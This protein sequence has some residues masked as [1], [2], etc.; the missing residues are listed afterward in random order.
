MTFG[1]S[2]VI[3][4]GHNDRVGWAATSAAGAVVSGVRYRLNL[5]PGS[6]TS[7]LVD[8]VRYEMVPRTVTVQIRNAAGVIEPYAHTFYDTM[9]GMVSASTTRPWTLQN[10]YT[11]KHSP[12]K[13]SGL[14]MW[15]LYS[16]A[17]TVEDIHAADRA[18]MGVAWI[19]T[20]AADSTGRAY[21]SV[22]TPLP[23]VT[24]QMLT[25]CAIVTGI[26]DGTRAACAP[27]VDPEAPFPGVFPPS[28]MPYLFRYDYAFN[29]NG[30]H[31]LTNPR[32]P[33]T[34]YPTLFGPEGAR[35]NQ[36]T[37][38][39]IQMIEQRLQGT[40]GLPGK[41]F[42]LEQLISKTFDGRDYFAQL[43]Q[44]D[45]VS[46]CDEVKN[47]AGAPARM[48]EG[49]AALAAWHGTYSLDDPGAVLYRRFA[50]RT[51]ANSPQP[52]LTLF[53]TTFDPANPLATPSGL[54]KTSVVR[55]AL[56]GAVN[57]LVTSGIPINA[58]MRGYQY[59]LFG[60]E[61][62]PLPGGVP[63]FQ[64]LYTDAFLGADGWADTG[65]GGSSF[66]Y[67]VE[68]T[69]NGPVGKQIQVQGQ[70]SNSASPYYA[71]QTRLYS[72]GKYLDIRF[73]ESQI[74]ADPN[75]TVKSL[76]GNPE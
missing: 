40:D 58:A 21:R 5:V 18:T 28:K 14:N 4:I 25:D 7:Y 2:P 38:A 53:T 48:A 44:P 20:G 11:L 37:H 70:S 3:G 41:G 27:L 61:R 36:R 57:D 22:P 50:E 45:L 13:L 1:A 43:W 34:G 52:P 66:V 73:T 59:G 55:D 33:M 69:P 47:Q 6:P 46:F 23:Y 60:T 71:V 63:N 15:H 32:Q 75:L 62:I 26:L 9:F 49:C 76:R 74:A 65:V 56:Y 30:S 68:L 51:G 39:G 12:L 54:N 19:N 67:W 17:R 35:H 24:N 42:T 29:A 64:A 8:G 16:Q 31:W 72:Q 10:A